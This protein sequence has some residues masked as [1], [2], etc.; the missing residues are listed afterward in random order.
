MKKEEFYTKLKNIPFDGSIDVYEQLNES[1]ESLNDKYARGY[2]SCYCQS[3]PWE[4][5]EGSIEEV[6]KSEDWDIW[7]K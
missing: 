1:I 4:N 6:S 7:E 3:L 5:M 2:L